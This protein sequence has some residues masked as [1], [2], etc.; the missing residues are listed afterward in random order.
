MMNKPI[1]PRDVLYL[2]IALLIKKSGN[3]KFW[4]D[5]TGE[6]ANV[7]QT[8]ES[9]RTLLTWDSFVSTYSVKTIPIK[10]N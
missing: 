3:V 1:V 7:S 6:P 8:K 4:V 5:F 10:K 9:L 2:E